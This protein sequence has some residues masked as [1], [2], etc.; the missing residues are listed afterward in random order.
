M[1]PEVPVTKCVNLPMR[2]QVMP[3]AGETMQAYCRILSSLAARKAGVDVSISCGVLKYIEE[4]VFS[5]DWKER[6]TA[7]A[8]SSL[9]SVAYGHCG[10][11]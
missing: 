1:L 2:M 11:V 5:A 10:L 3:L 7:T 8:S 9:V 4:I 6:I